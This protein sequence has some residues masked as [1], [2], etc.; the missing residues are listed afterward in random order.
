M[1]WLVGELAWVSPAVEHTLWGV[2]DFAAKVRRAQEDGSVQADLWRVIYFAAIAAADR[3]GHRISDLSADELD[4]GY[5]WTL[6]R[7]WLDPELRAL[8][9]S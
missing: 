9:G 8:L 6:A 7:P 3:A 4:A 5:R 1:V 2:C